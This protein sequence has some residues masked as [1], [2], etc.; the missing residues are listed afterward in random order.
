MLSYFQR[1]CNDEKRNLL[2]RIN[3]IVEVQQYDGAGTNLQM[4]RFIETII[5]YAGRTVE[6]SVVFDE[7]YLIRRY[8]ENWPPVSEYNGEMGK[9]FDYV[10]ISKMFNDELEC[11]FQNSSLFEEWSI[12]EKSVDYL[13]SLDL[14][15]NS[16][17]HYEWWSVMPKKKQICSSAMSLG[18]SLLGCCLAPKPS[19]QRIYV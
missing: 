15:D 8:V 17:N 18:Q 4:N 19:L 5:N 9:N 11:H 10:V 6:Q 2:K 3:D 12:K 14:V 1:I 16:G 13:K 7:D